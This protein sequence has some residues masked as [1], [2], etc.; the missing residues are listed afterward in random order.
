M[1]QLVD[2]TARARLLLVNGSF[3]SFVAVIKFAECV[4][5]V[6]SDDV[7]VNSRNCN[8]RA[9]NSPTYAHVHPPIHHCNIIYKRVAVVGTLRFSLLHA[10]M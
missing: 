1:L 9:M 5:A 4:G 10:C 2:S 6:S 8:D 7:V 3:F